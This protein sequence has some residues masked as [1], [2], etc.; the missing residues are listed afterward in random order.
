MYRFF[1]VFSQIEKKANTMSSFLRSTPNS[2]WRNLFTRTLLVVVSTLLI[3][4]LLPRKEGFQFKYEIG[5]PWMGDD[6]I[7]RFKFPVLKTEEAIANEQN[8]L[9]S[10][11]QP[12]YIYDESVENKAV[13]DFS[14]AFDDNIPPMIA[15]F[16]PHIIRRLHQLY[17][18]GI[19]NAPDYSRLSV[20]STAQVRVVSGK[21]ATSTD[22]RQLLST[23]NAYEQIFLD[24]NLAERRGLLLKYDLNQY[25]RPNL[26]YDKTRSEQEL[27]ELV[28]SIAPAEGQVE[29]GQ[30]IIERG[31][32]VNEHTARILHS[33]EQELDNRD[34]G[35][36][37]S[38]STILGQT[39]Y[40]AMLI[41]LFTIYLLLFRRDYFSKSRNILMLY[42][43]IT[44]F[45]IAVAL[46]VRFSSLSVYLL[47]FAMVA[48]FVRIFLDSRTAFMAHTTMVMISASAVNYQEE[49]F[50][51]EMVAGMAAIFSLRDMSRRSQVFRAMLSVT[52]C[53]MV[54][55][56]ALT[57][58][59]SDQ[60]T[61]ISWS[62][63]FHLLL[64]GIFLL[65]AYPL[66][67]LI[68][69]T[70]GFTSDV[71]LFELSDTNKDLL[72]ELSEVAPGTFQHSITVGNLA[73]EIANKID[74]N[75]LLVRTGAL[76]HDIGKMTNPVFFTENQAGVN[77]HNKLSEKESAQ[78]IISHVTDGIHLAEK[79]GLPEVIK[80]FILTHHGT[81]TTK[82]FYITY[83]NNHPDEADNPQPFTYPGP[84]PSTREQAILMMADGVEAASRSL[85]EYTEESISQLVNRMIDNMVNEGYFTECPI[86]F[87]D[88][89]LAKQ[90]LIDRLRSIYHTRIR[91]P[92]T[93]EGNL[94]PTPSQGRGEGDTPRTLKLKNS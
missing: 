65:L 69:K 49:F 85:D 75:G 24:E 67:F 40:V 22:V 35:K 11:F 52:V 9:A 29:N 20:D 55:H 43:L 6:V 79:N 51:I 82:F 18:R 12:Y 77:P 33:L 83:K 56:F 87:R 93:Q 50:I 1:F 58:I 19:M 16:K 90:V 5:K 21:E 3:V 26:T 89:V 38:M 80:N 17:Q 92:E 54:M 78:I 44:L 74:A 23:M 4:W 76:Y 13:E 66:M 2:F 63:Y 14:K 30:K 57:L 53:T 10:K 88:I 62:R 47:P 94:P 42:S 84:N 46:M 15:M 25:I 45:P 81:G 48:I 60:G 34:T 31:E 39:I 41:I 7:A 27:A 73:A 91:Y 72:R 36:S 71:T 59:H 86:T 64:N 68:E 61:A 8:E 70:F 37:E 28:S 32:I